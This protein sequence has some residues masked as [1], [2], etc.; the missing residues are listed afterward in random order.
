MNTSLKIEIQSEHDT[1]QFACKCAAVLHPPAMI[2]LIGQLGAGKTTFVRYFVLATGITV[3]VSSPSFVLSH[4]YTGINDLVVEHWDL[5][6]ISDIPEELLEPPDRSI[7]RLVEW[8]DKIPDG[9]CPLDLL[10][11]ISFAGDSPQEGRRVIEVTGSSA[12]LFEEGE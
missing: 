10:L 5:Y 8:A 7:I 9:S 11:T 12:H 4:E 6:R 2:G 3:P 1:K